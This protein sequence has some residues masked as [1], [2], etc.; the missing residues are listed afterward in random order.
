M[1]FD[2]WDRLDDEIDK[3][4]S[5]MSKLTVQGSSK[6][7]LFKPKI[8]QGES[9]GQTMNCYNQDRYQGRYRSNSS[10]RRMAYRGRTQYR[11]NYRE[12]SQYG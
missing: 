8:Y 5:M 12:R 3:P 10:D 2:T 1:S 4:I 9:R 11:H 6:N 7:R